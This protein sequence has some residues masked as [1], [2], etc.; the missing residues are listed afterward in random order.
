MYVHFQMR[1]HHP[2]GLT[3]AVLRIQQI[4]LRLDVEQ[5]AV[6]RQRNAVGGPLGF[7]KVF[8]GDLA[9]P[10][11]KAQC[12]A[13]IDTLDV[14]ARNA[15]VGGVD[16]HSRSGFGLLDGFLDGEPRALEVHDHALAPALGFRGAQT[17]YF[18]LR[19]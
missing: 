14:G 8:V 9:T 6:G 11:A 17:H 10:V 18:Q 19:A 13:R 7:G 12:S 3:N 4:L 16:G 2:H 15:D 5:L 1:P